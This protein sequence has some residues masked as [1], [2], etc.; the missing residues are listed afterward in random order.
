MN[1]IRGVDL[2]RAL[3]LT[4]RVYLCGN[5]EKPQECLKWIPDNKL[6]IGT[7]FYGKFTG[8]HPH[9]HSV[10][11]EYNYVMC[12][13]S[14]VLMID[15]GKEYTFGEDTLFVIPPHTRYASKH[16]GGTKILF[17]KNPGGNDKNL[18]S[19]DESLKQWLET[20]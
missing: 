6:E 12:G 13:T 2:K 7:S 15:E 14:K 11:T 5:L 18:I 17:V 16:M 4:Y 9:F 3:Q 10:A 1:F 8:D 19:V 20:W